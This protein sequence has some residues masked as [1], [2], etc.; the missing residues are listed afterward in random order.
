MTDLPIACSLTPEQ[1][2]TRR[3]ELLPGLVA[4]ATSREPLP[5]GYRWSF[6]STPGLVGRIA[7]V[8]EAERSC[9]RFLTFHVEAEPDLGPVVLE[10]T[11]PEGTREFL[12]QLV[13]DGA[14]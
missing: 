13:E 7:E 5:S 10:V 1:R 9:C 6:D 8:I 3:R 11:G 4:A 12:D 14:S 2:G